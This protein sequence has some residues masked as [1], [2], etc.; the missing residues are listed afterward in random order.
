M[1]LIYNNF[2]DIESLMN[3][4][5]C[6]TETNEH[7]HNAKEEEKKLQNPVIHSNCNVFSFFLFF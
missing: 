6:V 7:E 5:L 1:T 2:Y 3:V 4:D